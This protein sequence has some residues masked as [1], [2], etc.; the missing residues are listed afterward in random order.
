MVDFIKELEKCTEC[1]KCKEICPITRVREEPVYSPRSKSQ[2]L[3]KLKNNEKLTEKEY[4]SIYLCTRCGICDDYCPED[5]PISDI[6][7]KEREIIAKKGEEPKKTSHIVNNI[8]E[9]YNPGGYEVSERKNWVNEELEFSDNSKIGY[10]AGCWISYK[11][12]EIAQNTIKI[13]N[14][15]GIKPQ[16]IDQEKCCGLF[17]TDN[18]H[19]DEFEEYAKN[20][21]GEIKSQGIE[22]L[23]VSCPSCYSQ[24]KHEYAK[25]YEEPEF[26]VKLSVD[27]FNKLLKEERLTLKNDDLN[28]SIKD[29][30]HGK[31]ASEA[32][33]EILEETNNGSKELSEEIICCGAPAGV[34]PLYPDISDDIGML[35]IE[36]ADQV[37]DEMI[38][39]CPFC[40]YHFEDV[41]ERKKEDAKPI[42]DLTN[43]L[44]R[45]IE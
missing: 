20:Y 22:K 33:R 21:M 6:I 4:D 42:V 26:E 7:Q 25:Q 16:L 37:S 19:V 13:L 12:P 31:D 10:M 2:L 32:P 18:G 3:K 45:L 39:Y 8:F 24:M 29:G 14:K 40:L 27:F 36:K 23:I 44:I 34:K 1:G 28:L 43:H 11:H 35:S 30:C 5:I 9:K 41:V 17:V 15:A 38:T